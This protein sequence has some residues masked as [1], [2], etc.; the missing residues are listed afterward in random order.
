MSDP[1]G[2]SAV[3]ERTFDALRSL[4]WQIWTEPVYF[5][6]WYCLMDASIPVSEGEVR[7]GGRHHICMAMAT[8]NGPT[9][10][11]FRGDDVEIVDDEPTITAT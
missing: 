7:I 9:H 10:M 8:P 3:I 4:M 1:S 6:A 5:A 11:R 2:T